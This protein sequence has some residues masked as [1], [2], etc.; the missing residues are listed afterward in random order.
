MSA[1]T[2]RFAQL[3]TLVEIRLPPS[4]NASFVYPFGDDPVTA[5]KL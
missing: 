1:I 5:I 2:M 3:P 4:L